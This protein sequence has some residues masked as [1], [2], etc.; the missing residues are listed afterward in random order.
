MLLSYNTL[1]Y[2]KGINQRDLEKNYARHIGRDLEK[3]NFYGVAVISLVKHHFNPG[4]PEM[5]TILLYRPY[6]TNWEN[7]IKRKTSFSQAISKIHKAV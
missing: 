4:S 7:E 5:E 6:H 1:M 2:K 3:M